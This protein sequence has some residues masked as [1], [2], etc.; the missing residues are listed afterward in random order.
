MVNMNLS[1]DEI[2]ILTLHREKGQLLQALY[3]LQ[4]QLANAQVS[5]FCRRVED[6]RK[7]PSGSIGQTH[8]FDPEGTE[9]IEKPKD[10]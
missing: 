6:R 10:D 5:A 4:M 8:D 3:T 9:V 1:P 7:L 2:D